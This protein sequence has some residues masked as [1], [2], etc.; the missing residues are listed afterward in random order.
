MAGLRRTS[1]TVSE[2]LETDEKHG[3]QTIHLQGEHISIVR[4]LSTTSLK[5]GDVGEIRGNVD[6]G[7]FHFDGKRW[8]IDAPA[9]SEKD[10]HSDEW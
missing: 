10:H 6:N 9:L 2:V 8:R 1:V 4:S 5:V 7:T 3:F